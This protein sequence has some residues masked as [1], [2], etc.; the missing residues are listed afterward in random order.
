MAG[1]EAGGLTD[2]SVTLTGELATLAAKV[3][4]A[5]LGTTGWAGRPTEGDGD[6]NEFMPTVCGLMFFYIICWMA[7]RIFSP[8]EVFSFSLRRNIFSASK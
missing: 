8:Q 5:A 6:Y 1:R 2:T 3:A 7:Q 4:E